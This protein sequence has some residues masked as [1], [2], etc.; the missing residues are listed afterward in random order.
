MGKGGKGA[1]GAAAGATKK[2][3]AGAPAG[4]AGNSGAPEGEDTPFLK[5]DLN[6]AHQWKPLKRSC[7]SQSPLE[8][9][10]AFLLSELPIEVLHM[11]FD[12]AVRKKNIRMAIWAILSI[13]SIVVEL[14][15][16]FNREKFLYQKL[17][18][19]EALKAVNSF[20]TVMLLY[21]LYD[22]Y[23]YQV[24]GAKK[25]WYKRLYDG[26]NPGPKPSFKSYAMS[27]L[28]EFVVLAFHTPPYFDFRYWK[29]ESGIT[30]PLVSDKLAVFCFI[31]LYLFIR[32]VRDGARVYSRRRLIYDGGY[33]ER[34]GPEINYKLAMKAVMIQREALFVFV[35][36]FGSVFVLGYMWHVSERDWQ[37][38]DFTLK[39]CI[40]LVV[41]QLCACDYNG[42]GPKSEIG[43][44][45]GLLVISWGLII[46]SML[47]NVIFN[48]VVLSSYEGW[49]VDWLDQYELCETQHEAS[50]DVLKLWWKY[51]MNRRKGGD[52]AAA[53]KND[54]AQYIIQLVQK[55]KYL[56]EVTFQVATNSGDAADP[57]AEQQAQMRT[58]L[59][60]L[61]SKMHGATDPDGAADGAAAAISMNDRTEALN[62]RVVELEETAGVVLAQTREV[63]EK[64]MGR[65]PE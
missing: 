46:I 26:E 38:E 45:M 25:D 36:Y 60:V 28:I 30:K 15:L 19:C 51:K 12:W 61:M 3:K 33:R 42:L 7:M 29:L 1:A 8:N 43:T 18:Y 39:Q 31:R 32:V 27:F 5:D 34:G 48:A 59:N 57:V 52:S 20:C 53:A 24:A 58:D 56:R 21:Y 9:S 54:E 23:D 13:I 22:Y 40:W 64:M 50:A 37:P 65:A 17:G 49:A 55:Y 63:F 2:K 41:F 47:V 14:E 62:A 44:L 11:E 16:A 35:V 6:Q 4:A 10:G